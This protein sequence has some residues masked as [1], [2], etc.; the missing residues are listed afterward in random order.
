M[1]CLFLE[2]GKEGKSK[3]SYRESQ[4]GRETGREREQES[5]GGG[6]GGGM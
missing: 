3:V 2:P 4:R 6:G 5:A 1:L